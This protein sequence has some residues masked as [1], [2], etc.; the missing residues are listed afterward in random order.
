MT[1]QKPTRSGQTIVIVAIVA[2][3]AIVLCVLLS[4]TMLQLNQTG[5]E[6][7]AMT[8]DRDSTARELSTAQ[9]LL[10]ETEASLTEAKTKLAE[11]EGKLADTEAKLTE[12]EGKLTEAEGKL[13][14]TE[15]KLTETETA[16]AT[17]TAAQE[18]AAAALVQSEAQLSECQ[19]ALTDTEA[20]L[21]ETE[22]KLS[23]TEAKLTDSETK[24]SDAETKLSETEDA[25]TGSRNALSETQ[26]ILAAMTAEKEAAT[27]ALSD[28]E[29][30]LSD[31]QAALAAMT[32]EKEA[33]AA[34]LTDAEAKLAEVQTALSDAEAEI[35][36]LKVAPAT[37]AGVGVP[38]EMNPGDIA[39]AGSDSAEY[40][41]VKEVEWQ[42][43]GSHRL[44]LIV[45]NTSGESKHISAQVLFYNEAGGVVGVSKPE[46]YVC[47]NGEE[48]FLSCDCDSAYASYEYSLELSS[49]LGTSHHQEIEITATVNPNNVIL[50]AKNNGSKTPDHIEYNCLFFDAN[51]EVVDT[52]WGF[53][54]APAPGKTTLEEIST[55]KTFDRVEVYYSAYSF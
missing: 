18:T 54:D 52:D 29:T 6:L 16:L 19:T 28:R 46:Q 41:V 50:M 7:T 30:A 31:T 8:A 5:S 32:A 4:R 43:Y 26:A 14:E 21:V 36:R 15:A 9:S 33:A 38:G 35:N 10:A 40:V 24:L 1:K 22:G 49:A 39:L 44:A 11:T 25:L 47:A 42:Q 37:S 27:T 2:I 55:H 17:A 45:K 34:A 20:K 53:L 48:V 51:G 13:A 23:E 3:V 12:T